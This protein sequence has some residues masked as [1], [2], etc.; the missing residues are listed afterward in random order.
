MFVED[1]K[2][3]NSDI[4]LGLVPIPMERY[5]VEMSEKAENDRE[6]KLYELQRAIV[7]LRR[8]QYN[9]DA[10]K[11]KLRNQFI[12]YNSNSLKNEIDDISEYINKIVIIQKLKMNQKK[13]QKIKKMKKKK[14]FK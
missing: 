7:M 9:K 2:N 4:N 5:K 11:K 3:N 6:K 14:I 10:D 8:R 13:Y 1:Q 12:D